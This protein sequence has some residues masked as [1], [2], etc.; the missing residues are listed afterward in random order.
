MARFFQ[1]IFG[2]TVL[3]SDVYDVRGTQGMSFIAGLGQHWGAPVPIEIEAASGAGLGNHSI[4]RINQPLAVL[5]MLS[6]KKHF[7]L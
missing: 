4:G 5:G 3:A 2:V 6:L 1:N 7:F